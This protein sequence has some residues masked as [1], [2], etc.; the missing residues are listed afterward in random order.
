[1]GS[2]YP[3][4]AGTNGNA[5]T[6][7]VQGVCSNGWHLPCKDEWVRFARYLAEYGFAYDETL[8][9]GTETDE[10]ASSKIGKEL[11]IDYGWI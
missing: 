10:E 1:M 6:I 7:G 9:D 3:W 2:L 11:A 5:D 4:A 8:Y